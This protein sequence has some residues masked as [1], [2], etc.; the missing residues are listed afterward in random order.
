MTTTEDT[1]TPAHAHRWR[2][3]LRLHPAPTRNGAT[4][5]PNGHGE[6]GQV[7]GPASPVTV[8]IAPAPRRADEG[9]STRPSPGTLRAE[10][11]DRAITPSQPQR[12]RAPS[13]GWTVFVGTVIAL[14]AVREA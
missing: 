7:P 10:P 1:R 12:D 14:A 3:T 9:D 5:G 8:P 13:G 6:E 11:P 4:A 2:R